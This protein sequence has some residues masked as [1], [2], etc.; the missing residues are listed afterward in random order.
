MGACTRDK[1]S[2]SSGFN[3]VTVY[4]R[5]G[6][7]C[8]NFIRRE[9]PLGGPRLLC[10]ALPGWLCHWPSARGFKRCNAQTASAEAINTPSASSAAE[11]L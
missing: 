1:I 3:G 4:T 9:E 5:G 10:C 7:F 11:T 8:F 6:V 2:L